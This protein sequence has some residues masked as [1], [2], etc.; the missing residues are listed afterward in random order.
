MLNVV[1][2]W[3]NRYQPDSLSEKQI[4]AA[5]DTLING[6]QPQIPDSDQGIPAALNRLASHLDSDNHRNQTKQNDTARFYRAL[7]LI[8]QQAAGISGQVFRAIDL[9]RSFTSEIHQRAE[10]LENELNLA[11]QY[12]SSSNT[13]VTSLQEQIDTETSDVNRSIDESLRQI[14]ESL[15]TKADGATNVLNGIK[16]IGK[17]INLLA[18]NA[19]IE[20]ARAGEQGRGFAVVA[21]EV[22]QLAATTMERAQLATE[23]LDFAD[24]KQNLNL[25]C[26]TNAERLSEFTKSITEATSE[27]NNMFLSIESQLNAITD[28]TAVIFES[29]ELSQGAVER[30]SDKG[31][32]I[33]NLTVEM[34]KGFSQ[35]DTN[36]GLIANAVGAFDR[37][38]SQLHLVPDPSHD[39]LADILQRGKLRVAIEP[40]FVG[41]SFREQ[42]GDELKG[43][44]VDYAR[45]FAKSLGVDCEFIEVPWD[46]ATEL[47]AAGK[48]YGEPPADVVISALPPS[49]DYD[50][51]AYSETY[52]YLHWVLA[53]QTGNSSI[54]SINDLDG[55]TLG[56]INDPG[57]FQLLEDVGVRWGANAD[58]PGGKIRLA[59]LIAYSDQSRIHDCLANGVVNAFGVDLP[60]YYWACN[61]PASKWY[62]KIEIIPDNIAPQPYYYSIAVAES[63]SSYRLLKRANEFISEFK[64]QPGRAAMEKTWQGE[65]VDGSISYRDEAGNL[66]GEEQLKKLYRQHC[67]KFQLT[68]EA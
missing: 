52:T 6:E 19:A 2:T 43:L 8:S 47:L 39:Q 11:N 27:L 55:K 24:I 28:N 25:V 18:L 42:P 59:N 23:Q 50:N 20:A 1:R 65:S 5:I 61:N 40:S 13:T 36:Q 60:I 34:T 30:I 49:A 66:S 7:Q 31:H 12:L 21:D 48:S 9:Q 46:I 68:P 26:D 4:I 44:D 38:S 45:A 14:T 37:I 32:S 54:N 57:A 33:N 51:I 62:G 22:R 29:L 3:K 15:S 56:I 16:E 53:R 10:K 17:G 67:E 63:A 41:L 35:L 58:K 64:T